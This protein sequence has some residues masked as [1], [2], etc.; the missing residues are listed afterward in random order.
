MVELANDK[1]I[2]YSPIGKIVVEPVKI[3]SY[4]DSKLLKPKQKFISNTQLIK[5][6]TSKGKI[7]IT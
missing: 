3:N 6:S 5:P 2:I 7:F 4:T 1:E